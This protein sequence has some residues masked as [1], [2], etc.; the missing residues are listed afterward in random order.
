MNEIQ[1]LFS[2]V[3]LSLNLNNLCSPSF[4]QSPSQTSRATAAAILKEAWSWSIVRLSC[5]GGY[6]GTACLLRSQDSARLKIMPQ[7]AF[8][9]PTYGL[10]SRLERKQYTGLRTDLS[11]VDARSVYRKNDAT[12]TE[13]ASTSTRQS[14]FGP[15][16]YLT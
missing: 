10:H 14:M 7:A 16:S 4:R 1:S 5:N 3:T 13:Q 15:R 6:T 11:S 9:P 12:M 2:K 8:D